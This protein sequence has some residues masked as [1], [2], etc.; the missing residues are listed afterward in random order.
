MSEGGS[1]E[2][3]KDEGSS[4]ASSPVMLT[5]MTPVSVIE[6]E[7]QNQDHKIIYVHNSEEMM[8][9]EGEGFGQELEGGNSVSVLVQEPSAPAA[10]Q[11]APGTTVLVLSELVEDMSP[12]LG[13]R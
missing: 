3:V 7:Q 13:L 11:G 4:P 8:M 10:Y 5:T 12:L 9:G 1:P 2:A 6:Y